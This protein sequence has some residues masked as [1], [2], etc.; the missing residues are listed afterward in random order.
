MSE[1]KTRIDFNAPSSLVER[2]DAVAE[3]LDTSRTRILIDALRDELDDLIH[4]EEVRRLINDAYYR[5]ETDFETVESVLGT[6]EAL[7]MKL[8]RDSID[9]EP[10]QP[11]ITETPPDA[12]F[13]EEPISTWTPD[14]ETEDDVESL[15]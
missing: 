13:Y 4:A 9:R 11:E 7:R 5:G 14:E 15:P 10:P 3:L 8:L 1:E 2:V 12:E 6:E